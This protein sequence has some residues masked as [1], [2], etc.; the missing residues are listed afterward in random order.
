MK[1]YSPWLVLCLLWA[2][3][4]TKPPPV[5]RQVLLLPGKAPVTSNKYAKVQR[6]TPD[7]LADRLIREE[8]P[9][10]ET[11]VLPDQTGFFIRTPEHITLVDGAERYAPF[12][13]EAPDLVAVVMPTMGNAWTLNRQGLIQSWQYNQMRENAPVQLMLPAKSPPIAG[14]AFS[15]DGTRVVTWGEGESAIRMWDTTKG[16]S[17][18]VFTLQDH[19]SVAAWSLDGAFV[20]VGTLDG[21]GKMIGNAS[22]TF[23]TV[24]GDLTGQEQGIRSAFLSPNGTTLLT[25]DGGGNVQAWGFDS[26]F[27]FHQKMLFSAHESSVES[28]FWSNEGQALLTVGEDG[29]AT[30]WQTQIG[31][32][33]ETERWIYP[34]GMVGTAVGDF[35]QVAMSFD[36]TL[37]ATNNE[38]KHIRVFKTID[39]QTQNVPS[40]TYNK[41]SD[42]VYY[43]NA[44]AL[45]VQ[46][47][48]WF[49][50]NNRMISGHTNG[51]VRIWKLIP[52]SGGIYGGTGIVEKE[53]QAHTQAVLAT[54]YL[55]SPNLIATSGTDGS[56]ALWQGTDPYPSK[57]NI[58]VS[59]PL[60]SMAPSPS[61]D[62]LAVVTQDHAVTIWDVQNPDAVQ[63]LS[64]ISDPNQD[65]RVAA[66]GS[67]RRYVF[68][69]NGDGQNQVWDLQ[70]PK[71]PVL[72]RSWLA[73][74][75]YS[76]RNK[77]APTTVR[78]IVLC[79]GEAQLLSGGALGDVKTW[80]WKTGKLLSTAIN[81]WGEVRSLA[82]T[83]SGQ[84]FAYSSGL[85]MA[86]GQISWVQP[87][88]QFSVDP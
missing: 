18:F 49:P 61:G 5:P 1:F 72:Q 56:V 13:L 85:M 51:K 24:S 87:K 59:A 62:R 75:L 57:G 32:L 41:P 84:S 44:D 77:G 70:D 25:G 46:S 14:A 53:W 82:C 42:G 2:G 58:P 4:C 6:W 73:H 10:A 76:Y 79:G 40:A 81:N 7:G 8:E 67:D 21:Q 28:I 54:F 9:N 69:G 45:P 39:I 55:S 26:R 12:A 34:D 86:S 71:H 65:F 29:Q 43:L 64:V 68:T 52:P 80:D 23:P 60:L 33:G 78:A 16:K 11:F 3:M 15:K 66:L 50:T 83:P 19:P 36:S 38:D 27:G 88:A 48:G 74:T 63:K 35:F 30:L 37:V 47:L 20:F 22:S 31:S 17:L